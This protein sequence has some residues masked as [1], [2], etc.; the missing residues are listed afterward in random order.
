M[1]NFSRRRSRSQKTEYINVVD[2][3]GRYLGKEE[4]EKCHQGKGILHSAFLVMIFNEK[5]ELM[6]AKRSKEKS[7]WPDFWDGTVASHYHSEKNQQT[8]IKQRIFH[9]IGVSCDQINYLF[10]F[11]Y[12]VEYRDLGSE[13]EICDVFVARNIKSEKISPNISEI[14]E[15]KFLDIPE[16][17][18][19]IQENSKTYAPWF[20]IA[21]EKYNCL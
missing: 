9:E 17:K 14:S 1:I 21:L 2:K 3:N 8:T 19:K 18:E 11:H 12:H 16:L 15:F 13:N 20:L 4:K 6:L 7:L 10:K 5:N